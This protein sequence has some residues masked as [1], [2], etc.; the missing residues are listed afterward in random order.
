M[1]F[2]DFQKSMK[3]GAPVAPVYLIEGEETY[4]RERAV[5]AIR[6]ACV[7]NPELN[8]LRA[9]GE[10]LKGDRLVSFRDGLYALPFLGEKRMA[11]AY[12]FYPT[13]REY[14]SVLKGYFENPCP[15]TVFLIVN[16]ERKAGA[17]DLRR[18]SGVTYVDCSR[19]S[20][21]TLCKWLYGNLRRA[22][23]QADGEAVQ[24]MVRYCASDA[25]RMK[26]EIEKLALLLG[27]GGKVTRATVE[28][29]VA[30]DVEY[31]IYELTQAA[32][33]RSF[34]VFNE[35][36]S[37]LLRRGFD[38]NAALAALASHYRTL[39]EVGTMTGTDAETAKALGVKPYA[40]Q[41]NRE[42][43]QRLGREKTK[44]YYLALYELSC[45]VKGG[46][47]AKEGALSAAIAK[48][49]FS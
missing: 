34:T 37:D 38:E 13:E 24:T 28:E 14:E 48:I 23:L 1:K 12:G 8:D 16:A 25:A 7:V 29:H 46:L 17:V 9:E 5:E 31:K 18:K 4:F 10:T 6:N 41:K 15:S 42:A 30:K 26:R 32:S 40:V 39:Y 47:Y 36:L 35:I 11:R 2:I 43:A 22:G 45:G 33:R 27:E 20:E 3:E 49:F 19:E 21:E 44:E